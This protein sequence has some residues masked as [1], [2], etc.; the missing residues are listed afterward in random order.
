MTRTHWQ[1]I[2]CALAACL[3]AAPASA[4]RA[5]LSGQVVDAAGGQPV[6]AAVVMVLPRHEK[7]VT[8]A[9]GRFTVRTTAG[10]H[11]VVASALGYGSAYTV[12]TLG[13]ASGDVL[14]A[15]DRN[16]VMLEAITATASRLESRRRAFPYAVRSLDAAQVGSSGA[17]TLTQ[18][19]R[20]RLGVHLSPCSSG[21]SRRGRFTSDM[22]L[23]CVNSRGATIPARV[24]ID[25]VRM[26]D[27]EVL[28]LYT[29]AEVASVEVFQNGAQIRVY[30]RWFM[31]WAARTNYRPLPLSIS[32]F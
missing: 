18:L 30:T 22:A 5:T 10:E 21:F 8:D 28:S 26:P 13:D 3:A 31:E 20:E 15:L 14:M 25:E 23:N 24:Y 1:S 19:V 12:V 6:S 17:S 16:P 9:Q 27:L 32:S 4:Q 2:A 11:A 29:P 7:A